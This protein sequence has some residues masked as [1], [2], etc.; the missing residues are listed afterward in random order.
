MKSTTT[1]IRVFHGLIENDTHPHMSDKSF[2]K[3]VNLGFHQYNPK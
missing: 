2:V 3:F 1:G